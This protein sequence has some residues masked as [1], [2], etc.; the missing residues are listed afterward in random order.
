MII[1]DEIRK[2]KIFPLSAAVE[3]KII[4]FEDEYPYLTSNINC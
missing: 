3:F 4:S 2:T 1:M